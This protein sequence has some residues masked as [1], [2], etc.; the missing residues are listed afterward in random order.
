MSRIECPYC[1]T[2]YTSE[3]CGIPGDLDV[4]F[5][6]VCVTCARQIDGAVETI[7]VPGKPATTLHKWTWGYFGVPGTEPGSTRIVKVRE[8]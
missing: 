1:A 6:I 8:Q 5:T 4:V 7:A 2:S 3:R